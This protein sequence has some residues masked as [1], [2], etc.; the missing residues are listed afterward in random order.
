MNTPVPPTPPSSTVLQNVP[1]GNTSTATIVQSTITQ[2]SL[3]L[4]QNVAATVLSRIAPGQFSIQTDLGQLTLQT[5]ANLVLGQSLNVQ[6]QSLG[7]RP[8][9]LLLPPQTSAAGAPQT[10][11]PQVTGDTSTLTQGSVTKATILRSGQAG[12]GA[13]AAGTSARSTIAAATS[14]GVSATPTATPVGGTYGNPALTAISGSAGAVNTSAAVPGTTVTAPSSLPPGTTFNVRIVSV[15]PPNVPTPSNAAT[16]S[17]VVTGTVTGAT[18]SG[19][20]V[21]QSSAGEIALSAQKPLPRGTQLTLQITNTPQVPGGLPETTSLL[22]SQQW[23]SL[24][25]VIAALRSA[26][27]AA[28]RHVAQQVL[29]QAGGPITT[30]VLFFL[31]AMLTGDVRRWI[32]EDSMRTLQRTGGNLLDRLQRDMGDMRRMANEPA[33]Q[34][35]RS[36]LIPILSGSDLEQLKLFVRGERDQD[37][38]DEDSA[39]RKIRFVIEVEFSRLGP[40]Q[41]DGLSRER[42]IDL[43]VRTR[44]ALSKTMRDDI[45]RIYADA[46]SAL[47]FT[48]TI[49]FQ[50]STMFE[51]N[52]TQEVNAKQ[53]GLTV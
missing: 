23:E 34:E 8:L 40:F 36:Y 10:Q 25:D 27:P 49:D 43:M 37:E 20:P 50:R 18:A 29:P 53:S 5:A 15:T 2:S 39:G 41:F 47:G 30:G 44:D 52:P 7:A 33:G 45:R 16:A 24:R 13:G 4:G 32:G 19:Q 51:L 42:T 6:I 22:L 28:A 31:S 14:S 17:S 38:N 26:D 9:L 46:I 35:W 12:A 3:Q 11:A 1:T 48:G 21:V